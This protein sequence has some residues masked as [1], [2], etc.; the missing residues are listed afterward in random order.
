VGD[1]AVEDFVGNSCQP[2]KLGASG[3]LSSP[4]CLQGEFFEVRGEG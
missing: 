4:K 1:V 3:K 2:N